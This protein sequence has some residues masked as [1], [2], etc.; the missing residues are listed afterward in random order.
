MGTLRT[1]LRAQVGLGLA[2]LAAT[3]LVILFAVVG[4]RYHRTFSQIE[5]S[6]VEANVGRARN[7]VANELQNLETTSHDWASWDEPF[8]FIQGTLPSFAEENLMVDTFANLR[9]NFMVFLDSAHRVV[10]AADYGLEE[11][12]VP[13]PRGFL[14][15]VEPA[16]ALWPSRDDTTSRS[17]LVAL[18]DSLVLVAFHPVTASSHE[19][20]AVGMLV[21]GR[22][23]D[24]AEVGRLAAQIDLPL[25]VRRIGDPANA[26]SLLAALTSGDRASTPTKVVPLGADTVAGY[27]A[28]RDL[29]GEPVA[30]LELKTPRDTY[31]AGMATLTWMA[32][33]LVST[34]AILSAGFMLFLDRRVLVRTARL[35][36][37]VTR[38]AREHDSSQRVPVAGQD[39]LSRLGANIN[40]ML[41]SIEESRDALARSEKQYHNLF[42]SS[43][44]PIYITTE[45]GKFVDVNQAL[46]DLL[47]YS[48]PE[49]MMI[50]AGDLYV[51]RADREAFQATIQEKGFVTSFPVTL[52]RKDG[53]HLR[54][55]LTTTLETASGDAGPVYQGIIRDVTELLR[56]QE[57]LTFLATHDP[58]TGLLSRGALYEV[59]RL[60]IARAMRNLERLAVF[61]LDLDKFK[62]VND[63]H[64][65]AVGDRVLQ[66]VG[67]RLRE[68]LRESDTVARLG[69]DEFVA[70]L[71][72]IERPEDAEVAADKILR[73]LRATFEIPDDGRCG[74]SASIGI[75][76]YPD[77]GESGVHLLQK[78]DAAMYT[79][80]M[81]GRDGWRRF[82]AGPL[83]PSQS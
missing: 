5:R 3:V 38:I 26:A 58:L 79:V 74:L 22:M 52:K 68:A 9:L 15:A 36:S 30:V 35:S 13:V 61:Y 31:R 27:T 11:A 43:R 17:G 16:L 55:L 83:P 57:E 46:V 60:E 78:A 50:P 67:A 32:I 1:S 41:A 51:N 47:G 53:A 80:K 42:E 7:A 20:P 64:G 34:L 8:E 25:T 14:T 66:E 81:Q 72:G 18:D 77:D 63:T 21:I 70:L 82:E 6:E 2:L 12:G 49:I 69:G 23:L 39:E 56:Q 76:L 29:L 59:L 4:P 54:C 71:P 62:D 24:A 75:A 48:K 65:H 33:W 10:Y 19:P 45:A 73:A 44:D 37:D 40:G 28:W